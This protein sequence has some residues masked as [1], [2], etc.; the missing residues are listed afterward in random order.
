M[1]REVQRTYLELS[2]PA[3]CPRQPP[4]DARARLEP[5]LECPPSFFRYLYAEVGRPYHW[6]DRLG[7]TDEEIR[8]RLQDPSVSLAVL[9]VGGAPA[10]YFELQRHADG[11]MEIVYFGLLPEF[12]GRGLG[13]YLLAEAV[14]AARNRGATRV[15][16]HTCELDGPAAL[17]NY[18]ARGFRPFRA[19]TYTAELPD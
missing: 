19:E 15:W 18:L 17:P 8:A 3:A 1:K 13:R 5:L 11:A 7:W 14:A 4:P 10:G 9:I 2:D 16:L 12:H 6:R